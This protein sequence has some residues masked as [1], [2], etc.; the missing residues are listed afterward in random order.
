MHLWNDSSKGG[1]SPQE[2]RY[3]QLIRN[4]EQSRVWNILGVGSPLSASLDMGMLGA[5][6]GGDRHPNIG[7]AVNLI[8]RRWLDILFEGNCWFKRLWMRRMDADFGCQGHWAE[9]G[10]VRWNCS[11]EIVSPPHSCH[12][13]CALWTLWSWID[14]Q[15]FAHKELQRVWRKFVKSWEVSDRG[16]I[17]HLP[18][19]EEMSARMDKRSDKIEIF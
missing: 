7:P 15:L 18:L 9:E 8:L 6:Q 5:W 19:C 13:V 12:C 17:F 16:N 2:I 3:A 10:G 14:S 1:S 11:R 4:P